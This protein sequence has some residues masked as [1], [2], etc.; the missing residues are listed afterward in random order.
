VEPVGVA[1]DLAEEE[2]AD[3]SDEAGAFFEPV[4]RIRDRS[5]ELAAAG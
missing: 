2:V 3:R 1:R 5:F 4:E